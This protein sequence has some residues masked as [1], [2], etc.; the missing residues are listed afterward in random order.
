[1]INLDCVESPA[2]LIPTMV[3]GIRSALVKCN[4]NCASV[5][6]CN[7]HLL[8]V[9]LSLYCSELEY[10]FASLCLLASQLF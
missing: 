1:M 10:L 9:R 5:T 2:D 4:A 3:V 7:H 6:I 8:G